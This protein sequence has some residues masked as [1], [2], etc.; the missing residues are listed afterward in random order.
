MLTLFV[1]IA[2]GGMAAIF[3]MGL[4]DISTYFLGLVTIILLYAL[5]TLFTPATRKQ[6]Q[7]I[8][9]DFLVAGIFTLFLFLFYFLA[10]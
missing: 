4:V 9:N 10:Q 2:V 3:K 6:F 5:M 7:L 8:R 1:I